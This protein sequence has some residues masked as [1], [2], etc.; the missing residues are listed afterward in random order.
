MKNHVQRDHSVERTARER[1]RLIQ[2]CFAKCDQLLKPKLNG[3]SAGCR[4]RLRTHVDAATVTC[5]MF[6]DEAQRPTGTAPQI[7]EAALA[8]E[9]QSFYI[10]LQLLSGYPRVLT[11]V[12]PVRFPPELLLQRRIKVSI[13]VVVA[14]IFFEGVLIRP[15]KLRPA[16]RVSET[17][18]SDLLS[19]FRTLRRT[20]K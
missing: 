17:R 8:R 13:E 1:H 2:V 4:E 18:V 9:P 3:A 5:N 7:Q 19:G 11:D 14:L 20:T 10:L 16:A 12:L 6:D 15:Q